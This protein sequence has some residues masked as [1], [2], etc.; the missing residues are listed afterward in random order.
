MTD[1]EIGAVELYENNTNPLE[2]YTQE[3]DCFFFPTSISQYPG[4]MNLMDLMP[5]VQVDSAFANDA[6]FAEAVSLLEDNDML[7]GYPLMVAPSVIFYDEAMIGASFALSEGLSATEFEQLLLQTGNSD[8]ELPVF[9]PA[10]ISPIYILA[11][12]TASDALLYDTRQTPP[13]VNIDAQTIQDVQVVL[14]MAKAGLIEYQPLQEN[15]GRPGQQNAPL[16]EESWQAF[17]FRRLITENEGASLLPA[18][19]GLMLYPAGRQFAPLIVDVG[20]VYINAQSSLTSACYRWS[21]HLADNAHLFMGGMPATRSALD[22]VSNPSNM[23]FFNQVQNRLQ[24]DKLIVLPPPHRPLS[25]SQQADMYWLAGAFDAYVLDEANLSDEL[26]TVSDFID[27]LRDCE[28]SVAVSNSSVT[29]ECITTIDPDA[30]YYLQ[31]M[32]PADS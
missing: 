13:T 4:E 12:A 25:L 31:R 20:A 30:A 29:L 6:L 5:L 26:Q 14:D 2:G 22:T 18:E 1:D 16:K 7:Y 28:Q 15:N 24:S 8:I 3:T 21:Q 27:Q 32:L 17:E 11:L 19:Y 23:M 10:R 9:A